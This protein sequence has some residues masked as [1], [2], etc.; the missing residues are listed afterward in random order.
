MLD[1]PTDSALAQNH[2]RSNGSVALRCFGA[3]PAKIEL[4]VHQAVFC[5]QNNANECPRTNYPY[6]ATTFTFR[7][8]VLATKLPSYIASA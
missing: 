8:S 1:F 5:R 3:K 2:N 7:L 4:E 6:F